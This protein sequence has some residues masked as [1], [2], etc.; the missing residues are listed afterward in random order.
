MRVSIRTKLAGGFAVMVCLS[1]FLGG[2][3]AYNLMTVQERME[4]LRSG[5]IAQNER[6]LS[7]RS[8][9]SDI[10]RLVN[11]LTSV[12]GSTFGDTQEAIQGRSKDAFDALKQAALALRIV[13]GQACGALFSGDFTRHVRPAVQQIQQLVVEGVDAPAQFVDRHG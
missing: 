12:D 7:I 4:A 10:G 11:T 9:V 8:A 6:L 13:R 1:L 5:P 2:I 3:G